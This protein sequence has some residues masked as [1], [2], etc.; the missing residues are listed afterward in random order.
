M[1]DSYIKY[2]Y[3]ILLI[4]FIFF[5]LTIRTGKSLNEL[6]YVIAIGLDVGESN[7]LKLSLQISNPSA[8]GIA[9]SSSSSSQSSDSIIESIE[10]S[11]LSS[12]LN[13]F[14]SYLS[15]ELNLSHCKVLVLSENLAN[16][17]ISEYLYTLMNNIQFRSDANIVVCKNS[18][19]MFLKSSKPS[20]EQLS[21]RYYESIPTSSEYT[22]Y[23]ANITFGDFFSAYTDSF[24]DPV[25]ILGAINSK[26]S[27]DSLNLANSNSDLNIA[28]ESTEKNFSIF[29]TPSKDS[30]Y[31]AGQTPLK[32]QYTTENIGLA[33]FNNGKLVGEL[34]AIE[35]MCYLIIANKLEIAQISIPSPFYPNETMD[36][37]IKAN[38]NTK[39]TVDLVNGTPYINI[40]IDILSRLT[41]MDVGSNTLNEERVKKVEEYTNKYLE[42]NILSY[43]YKTSKDFKTD[44]NGFGRF[45]VKNFLIWNDWIDFNWLH[46]YESATFNV[47]V[48]SDFKSSYL[49][50]ES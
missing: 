42:E 14:N 41:S 12:G 29:T 10:C 18:S 11:S 24:S 48:K 50:M 26:F 49:L 38:K 1:N 3:I 6:A 21:A 45:A 8:S 33:A 2:V 40:N 27:Q 17:D 44:I 23:T 39:C 7:K 5:S 32:S 9:E 30:S 22:G 28:N 4:I 15:K 31:L 16:T 36:I 34:N 46:K 35:T 47:T 20:L 37:T 19:E 13:L 43:L 25:A